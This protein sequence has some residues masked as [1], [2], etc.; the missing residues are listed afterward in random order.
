MVLRWAAFV[1]IKKK[2]QLLKRE[3]Y[4]ATESTG[5]IFIRGEGNAKR[6][7]EEGG[8]PLETGAAEEG[9]GAGPQRCS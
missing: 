9:W 7:G 6:E 4:H 1:V 8:Q 2:K 3:R 5:G